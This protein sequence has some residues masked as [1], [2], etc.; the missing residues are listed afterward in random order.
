MPTIEE[1]QL[2]SVFIDSERVIMCAKAIFRK[3]WYTVVDNTRAYGGYK[4]SG[5]GR[6]KVLEDVG[7]R[8]DQKAE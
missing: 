2:G 3:E 8:I 1:L 5:E 7:S 6:R 4:D